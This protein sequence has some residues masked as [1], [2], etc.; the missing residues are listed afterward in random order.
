MRHGEV[1]QHQ[2]KATAGKER[3]HLPA[4]LAGD[5]V[6]Q[7]GATF[8]GQGQ[9]I[10]PGRL[11]V[12]QQNFKV[13]VDGLVHVVVSS[14]TV[15]KARVTVV[16]LPGVDSKERLPPCSLMMP[17]ET[18][19]P[20]PVPPLSRLVVKNGSVRRDRCSGSMPTPSSAMRST[21]W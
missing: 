11:I 9:G 5:Q 8:Q 6:I 21:T 4:F 1:Q 12:D 7:P 15:G 19:R 18:E 3:H 2:A 17:A 13:G 10:Q 16:P 20:R 14:R